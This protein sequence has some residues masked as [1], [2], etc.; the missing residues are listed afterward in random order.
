MPWSNKGQDSG[1]PGTPAFKYLKAGAAIAGV[2]VFAYLAYFYVSHRGNAH[3]PSAQTSSLEPIAANKASTKPEKKLW[4]CPMHPEII[5]DHPGVCPI[6]GMDL[7][8]MQPSS[9]T[10]AEH[11]HGLHLDTASLQ[12]LGVRLA[13]AKWETVSR[14]IDTYGN[15]AVDES[16]VINVSSNLGGTI[17][18]LHVRSVGEHV[19]AGQALYDIF[20]PELIQMQREY[21]DLRKQ[22]DR[23]VES[24]MGEDAHTSGKGMSEDDMMDVKMNSN[25]RVVTEEKLAFA[26]V[27]NDLL[28]ELQKTFRPREVVA[29][30]SPQSGFITKIDAHE[31]S[32]I[33]PMDTLFSLANLSHVWVDVAL[34]PDQLPWIKD[35]DEVTLQLPHLGQSKIKTRLQFI[36]PMVDNTSRTVRARLEAPNPKNQLLPGALVD[37]TIHAKPHLALT[38]PRSAVMRTGKGNFVM[39]SGGEG[40]FTPVGVET[41]IETA[42]LVEITSGLKEHDLVAV[43]GQFLLDAA[44]S[45]SAAAQRM[46]AKETQENGDKNQK[47]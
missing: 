47:K 34:Y 17:K 20:S 40:H 18:K 30:R 29:I 8:E 23:L 19:Q 42:D 11:N 41:G 35:G 6:C 3:A 2:I 25:M 43:N 45:L 22:K 13:N 31:G 44:A 21:I 24:M 15:V 7:V 36:S 9:K 14:N 27:G 26:N 10:H 28:E 33:K 16:M 38:V 37:V 12:K 4:V 39:M 1:S 46:R 5:Q 32:S